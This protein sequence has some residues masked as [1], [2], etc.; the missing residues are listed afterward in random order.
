[1]CVPIRQRDP[2][3]RFLFVIANLALVAGL[4]LWNFSCRSSSPAPA[5]IDGLT[6]LFMGISIAVNLGALI[7]ARR[8]A[9][10]RS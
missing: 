5:W 7:C 6:G 10:K 2:R 4:L 1:M 9:Q 8:S 3:T